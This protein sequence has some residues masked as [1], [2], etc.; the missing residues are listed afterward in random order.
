MTT[1]DRLLEYL[2]GEYD[3]SPDPLLALRLTYQTGQMLWSIADDILT[4]T[5]AAAGPG[6]SL[7]VDLSQYTLSTL[8]VFL[9]SQPGYA[10]LYLDQTGSSGLSALALVPASGDI[11]TSNGDHI[12]VA[13]NPNW[14]HLAAIAK[15]LELV[16]TAIALG[17]LEMQTTTADG[18]WLDVLGSYY[19]VPRQ[20][21]EQDAQYS[22]RIPAE[23]ILPRQNNTAIAAALEA[24]TAQIATVV[25]APIFGHPQPA[26]DGEIAF[27]GA[28]HFFNASAALILNLF[29]VS[30]GY[31]ILGGLS[32]DDFLV[33]IRRQI[34]R[35]R[36]AGTHLRNLTMT[37]SIMGDVFT[38]PTDSLVISLAVTGITGSGESFDFG[39]AVGIFPTLLL[40]L[41]FSSNSGV[42]FLSSGV[43]LVGTGQSFDTVAQFLPNGTGF[44]ADST[45]ADLSTNAP[46]VL[47]GTGSSTDGTFG[48]LGTAAIFN[49]VSSSIDTGGS[50]PVGP[51]FSSGFSSG[52]A[53][54]SSGGA[55][56]R[57]GAGLTGTG[58]SSDSGSLFRFVATG[59]SADSATGSLTPNHA[60]LAGTG[61]SHDT[62]A[63]ATLQS[64]TM[65]VGTGSSTDSRTGA[66]TTAIKLAGT[67][68]GS[69]SS[70]LAGGPLNIL[71][72]SALAGIV[73]GTP[74]TLPTGWEVTQIGGL[75]LQVVATGT[76]IGTGQIYIDIR[77]FGTSNGIG[78][79]L[80]FSTPDVA[81]L[82]SWPYTQSDYVALV[83]GSEANIGAVFQGTDFI[84]SGGNYLGSAGFTFLTLTGSVANFQASF[85]SDPATAALSF[86]LGL[87]GPTNGGAIDITLRIVYPQLLQN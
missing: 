80:G 14:T 62:A 5:V 28:P 47:A 45:H 21:G 85:T 70:T 1:L 18:T 75:N 3:S 72:N 31:A 82:P 39:V 67:G 12:Y 46:V 20:L 74:G 32:P 35:L 44:S 7:S 55:V 6:V 61:S 73:T 9:G 77:F 65:L 40:P 29:D 79:N 8:A 13:Q 52:F 24:S 83:A 53:R 68:A 81:G 87:F 11:A 76:D 33:L 26:Y 69:D 58:S 38:P 60:V 43:Q 71:P 42:G 57:T 64:T 41:S 22:P 56:L 2:T 16:A 63:A 19:A 66:L 84:D 34:D 15:E 4:T 48:S 25:D 51:S 36:A 86:G 78:V 17:P 50:L 30:I 23:V 49:G 27:S 37:P 59:S 54:G 10:V